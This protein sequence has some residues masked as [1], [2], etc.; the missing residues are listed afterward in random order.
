MAW[1]VEGGVLS[2]S[3]LVFAVLMLKTPLLLPAAACLVY[4]EGRKGTPGSLVPPEAWWLVVATQDWGGVSA[5]PGW[6]PGCF[7]VTS[8]AKSQVIVVLEAWGGSKPAESNAVAM[9]G[10][11]DF[12]TKK[13]AH[14]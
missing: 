6:P 8:R 12:P 7:L 13:L 2:A 5:L 4:G 9:N 11:A 1:I 10:R 14:Q 3:F